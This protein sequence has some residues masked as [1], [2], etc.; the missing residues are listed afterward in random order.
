MRF[1]DRYHSVCR[2]FCAR[3]PRKGTQ[4][5]RGETQILI[6]PLETEE[7]QACEH[8]LRAAG[9]VPRLHRTATMQAFEA[10]L[11]V[12]LGEEE[13]DSGDHSLLH[14]LT[15]QDVAG[16]FVFDLDG[17]IRYVN[18]KFA[19][20]LGYSVDEV[21]GRNFAPFVVEAARDDTAELFRSVAQGELPVARVAAPVYR[22]DGRTIELLAQATLGRYR[23]NP[24][25]IGIV[26]DVTAQKLDQVSLTRVN[27]ALNV[28][29]KTNEALVRATD[30]Q[31]LLDAMC[32]A[33][34]E[35][36]GYRV[37][38]IGLT[39]ER[40][41]L[42]LR[43]LAT[44]GGE[45]ATA[46]EERL[47][48]FAM[49]EAVL[50]K[51]EAS[52]EQDLSNRPGTN[53]SA[54]GS[55]MVLPLT[56]RGAVLGVLTICAPLPN[57]F[58]ED[59]AALL[60][61]LAANLAFGIASMRE[62]GRREASEHG[63]RRAMEAAVQAIA[64]T[65]E[66]RDPYT[67]GHQR[68]VAKLAVAIAHETGVPEGEIEG[69][70][71]AAVVHDIGK[72]RI[73]IDILSKPGP[74]TGLEYELIQ[75]HAQIGY[76]IMRQVD[77]PWPVAEMILEHHERLDGSGYPRGLKADAIL[78]GAK[79]LAVADVVQAMSMRRP[80]RGAFGEAAALDE[81]ERGRGT[82]YDPAAVDACLKLFREKGFR[83]T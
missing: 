8:A 76:D 60:R 27:H 75:T 45:E 24:A 80:Y 18:P 16:I 47:A 41:G 36:G 34:V 15:E 83:F 67:A 69:I 23:G 30:E 43:A 65:L 44:G 20:M 4:A 11:R 57:A 82:L 59:E 3:L 42:A 25:V 68:D 71:L 19:Q 29:G 56:E 38:W 40:P 81:I 39:A 50:R 55:R 7:L 1:V 52:I 35:H 64:S 78:P 62:R 46:T 28:L 22:K 74:L 77:F 32:K 66:M 79:I 70:Y 53:G 72:I 49:A 37:A 14:A 33:L 61:Q 73:P 51:G 58:T 6:A 17:T 54:I 26:L 13:G 31:G 5:L 21:L 48:G 10:A 2:I 63:L 9:L 12:G